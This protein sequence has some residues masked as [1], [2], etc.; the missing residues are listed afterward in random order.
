MSFI[1]DHNSLLSSHSCRVCLDKNYIGGINLDQNKYILELFEYCF[2]FNV[3]IQYSP[4]ILCYKCAETI[5]DYAKFKKKCVESEIF[6]NSFDSNYTI[7]NGDSEKVEIKIEK[8]N[9]EELNDFSHNKGLVETI[10]YTSEDSQEHS[11]SHLNMNKDCLYENNKKIEHKVTKKFECHKCKKQYSKQSWL[12]QHMKKLCYKGKHKKII[13]PK[14]VVEKEE[15]TE[16]AKLSSKCG[17]CNVS[18]CRDLKEHLDD[19]YS[20]NDLKCQICLY[21]GRDFADMITHRFEHCPERK[22]FCHICDKKKASILS[23]QFHFRSFHLQTP[24]G[25]CSVCN[26]TFKKFKTWKR[27][28]RLHNEN[29]LFVCDHCGRKFVF[30]HEIKSHLIHHTDVRQYVCETC[31]KGFKRMWGLKDHIENVHSSAQPVKCEHCNK[32]YKSQS[33]LELHMR[34]ISKD[35]PFVCEVCSKKF[36]SEKVLKKHMFWHTGERPFTCRICGSK[37]KAKGQLNLHM[38]NHT[39]VMPHKCINC[40]KGFP[41][42]YQLKRHRSVHTGVRAHKCEKCERSFHEKKALLEHASQHNSTDDVKTET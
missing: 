11:K 15:D 9:Y 28:E 18:N 31:G 20:N 8:V 32:I 12:Y 25:L 35:K 30:R 17:L 7:N 36:V 33:K 38:R 22:L 2:G 42:S 39:G 21:T 1:T 37:Y 13:I 26:K 19:H 34:N 24:G 6:W 4:K 29:S 41:N 5:Q 16:N 27:H 14:K 23:L 3:K 40:G 10:D